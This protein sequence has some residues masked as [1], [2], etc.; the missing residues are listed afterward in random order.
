MGRVVLEGLSH[1]KPVI[2][3]GYNNV[4]GLLD[5]TTFLKA[6]SFNFSGRNLP[7]IYIDAFKLQMQA[8]DPTTTQKI[9]QYLRKNYEASAIW[10]E[11][12][13]R[14]LQINTT[15]KSILVDLHHYILSNISNNP[16]PFF[17]AQ[18]IVDTLGKLIQSEKYSI[19]TLSTA[20]YYCYTSFARKIDTYFQQQ[21][22]HLQLELERKSSETIE[23]SKDYENKI[24][25]LV[26]KYNHLNDSETKYSS[27][28]DNLQTELVKNTQLIEK[29][30]LQAQ[31]N[32]LEK[33]QI[34]RQLNSLNEE[35]HFVTNKNNTLQQDNNELKSRLTELLAQ[36]NS[37][38][39][40]LNLLI[41]ENKLLES[42]L[43]KQKESTNQLITENENYKSIHQELVNSSTLKSLKLLKSLKNK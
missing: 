10:K 3:I 39:E 4:K 25:E 5:F 21:I 20:F 30:E 15:S 23:K 2:L 29:L 32:D 1:D 38:E 28:S 19:K 12:E 18:V 6:A 14:I 7:D 17:R 11:F 33:T 41:S 42:N 13:K 37:K 26:A 8:Y 34:E 36:I 9:S 40:K 43:S 16:T 35:I 31:Q 22:D 27:I 24:Q